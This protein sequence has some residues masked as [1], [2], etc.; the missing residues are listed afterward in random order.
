MAAVRTLFVAFALL[1]VACVSAHPA[2]YASKHWGCPEARIK[3]S[4]ARAQ[5]G[6]HAYAV[7][8]CGKKMIVECVYNDVNPDTPYECT[9]RDE[10]EIAAV[11]E[12][13]SLNG[14]DRPS[15]AT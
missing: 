12:S 15:V 5:A 9:S 2:E 13:R 6:G 10:S 14:K 1:S 11:F 8:G 4:D 7:T 3:V